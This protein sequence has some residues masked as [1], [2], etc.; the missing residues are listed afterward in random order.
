M[1]QAY[2]LRVHPAIVT[3]GKE[4]EY[5]PLTTVFQRLA[6]GDPPSAATVNAP[7]R[8]VQPDHSPVLLARFADLMAHHFPHLAPDYSATA[9]A[10]IARE[11]GS[12]RADAHAR[13]EEAMR[14][15][16]E[17]AAK[18]EKT[19]EDW[20]GATRLKLLLRLLDV[21]SEADLNAE[22]PVYLDMAKAKKS[23]VLIVL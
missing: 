5:A 10:Q 4:A 14:K 18:A 1:W 2:F 3:A 19:V 6:V 15:K 23:E 11:L 17:K 21:G 9:S 7:A 8:P 22:C 12:L 13:H 20:L 16:E